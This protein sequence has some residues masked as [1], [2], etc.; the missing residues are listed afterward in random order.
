[1]NNAIT[2]VAGIRVGHA[3]NV[4]AAT[5]C[6]V[7]LCEAGAVAAADVRGGAPGTREIPALDP[8]NMVERVHAIYLGG[9]SAYGLA[10]ATGV[11]EWLESR[12][13]GFDVG[14]G[15]V[16][17]VPGAVLFDLVIGDG[18]V[19][20]DAAMGR[21]ACEAATDGPVEQGNVGVGTGATVGKLGGFERATKSGVGTASIAV[22]ELTVGAIVA[23]NAVGDVVDP[24]S[25]QII[26]GSRSADGSRFVDSRELL[27]H[28]AERPASPFS[29]NTTIGVVA[30]NAHL[31]RGQAKRIAIMAH[32]GYSRAIRPVHTTYDGDSIFALSLGTVNADLN[33]LGAMAS[34][35]VVA[36][37]VNA[38]RHAED[39]HGVPAAGALSG[40]A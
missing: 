10:G 13:V 32:D 3:R 9:G 33:L 40:C 5:G 37:I 34:D 27:W 26:A 2:D 22:G 23:V 15:V 30:T 20:P 38:V 11:M 4:Q 39:S 17:I 21:A 6:T 19:R 8:A 25:G 1:M 35:A 31:T 36:A 16:P 28:S 18:R 14:V 24:D 7:V 29:E 12:G